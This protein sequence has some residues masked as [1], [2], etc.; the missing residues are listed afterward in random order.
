MG[1]DGHGGTPAP[2]FRLCPGRSDPPRERLGM[3]DALWG[4]ESMEEHEAFMRRALELA[5]RGLGLASPNPMVGAVLVSGGQVV[6][7][8]WHEGPGTRHAEVVALDQAGDSARGATLYTT[9]E[10]CAHQGRTPPCAPRIVSAGV[11]RVGSG[12]QDPHPAV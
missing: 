7:E 12:V 10:P 11:A 3:T 1:E 5:G 8:G 2:A 4:S 9:L 6:G